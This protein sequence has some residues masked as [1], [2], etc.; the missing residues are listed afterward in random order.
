MARLLLDG[1]PD[2]GVTAAELPPDVA[3][4]AQIVW[5]GWLYEWHGERLEAHGFTFALVYGF[6]GRR[7]TPDEIPPLIAETVEVWADAADM[8]IAMKEN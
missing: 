4:P 2:H 7:L 3:A 1:G 8:L 6:T 5:G